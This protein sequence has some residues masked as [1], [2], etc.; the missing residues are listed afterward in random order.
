MFNFHRLQKK[1]N[2]LFLS[3]TDF[4]DKELEM[5]WRVAGWGVAWNSDGEFVVELKIYFVY[6]AEQL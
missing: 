6:E 4:C 3:R 5:L 1:E 2:F